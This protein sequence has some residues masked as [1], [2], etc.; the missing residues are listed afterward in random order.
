MSISSRWAAGLD[1]DSEET[2]LQPLSSICLERELDRSRSLPNC[3]RRSA[4]LQASESPTRSAFP[5]LS[6]MRS[7]WCIPRV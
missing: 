2:L 7:K 1:E 5:V 6:G 3:E 4:L